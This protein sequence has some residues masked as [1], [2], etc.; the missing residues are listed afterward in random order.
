MLPTEKKDATPFDMAFELLLKNGRPLISRVELQAISQLPVHLVWAQDIE[1]ADAE[2]M[3][4]LE[5]MNLEVLTELLATKPKHMFFQDSVF[6]ANDATKVN[7]ALQCEA[8]GVK[9][10]SI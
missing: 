5:R 9:F 6:A 2:F 4:M 1:E 3:F 10:S 7:A 8:A